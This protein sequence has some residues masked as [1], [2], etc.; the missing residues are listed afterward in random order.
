M[1]FFARN[2]AF[3]RKQKGLTQSEMCASIGVPKSTYSNWENDQSEPSYEKLIEI[4]DFFGIGLTEF[5]GQ[6]LQE[7]KVI[8]IEKDP[9]NGTK[10]KENGKGNGK[11]T[12]E[13]SQLTSQVNEAQTAYQTTLKD[14]KNKD[15]LLSQLGDIA[16]SQANEIK[17]LKAALAAASAELEAL[18]KAAK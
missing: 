12:Y 3:L 18:K 14:L 8:E 7:G 2:L 5:M 10:G 9:K 13:I 15:R 6:N 11:P 1:N 16:E 17:T 4:S